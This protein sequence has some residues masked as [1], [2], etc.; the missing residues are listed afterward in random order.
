VS[1]R[2]PSGS[3]SWR[4]PPS[5][6][7]RVPPM[8]VERFKHRQLSPTVGPSSRS[9]GEF[10]GPSSTKINLLRCGVVAVFDRSTN[11]NS[12]CLSSRR[13]QCCP[14][15][16]YSLGLDRASR[17]APRQ[18]A[19][20]H[21]NRACR[22]HLGHKRQI[23]FFLDSESSSTH[24]PSCHLPGFESNSSCYLLLPLLMNSRKDH[25]ILLDPKSCWLGRSRPEHL[26]YS[27]QATASCG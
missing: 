16:A 20:E 3:G 24:A 17:F 11:C 21:Q 18:H 2:V 6:L 7:L 9:S 15:H 1:S 5:T 26:S 4:S 8:E 22:V 19:A 27:S 12:S 14:C 13:I 23:R 10:E 25:S